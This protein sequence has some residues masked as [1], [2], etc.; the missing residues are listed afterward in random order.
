M[1]K[2]SGS[3]D[4]FEVYP[5]K[6]DSVTN[7]KTT[8]DNLRVAL[9]AADL[10]SHSREGE[11]VNDTLIRLALNSSANASVLFRK[12]DSAEETKINAW[13]SIVDERAKSYLMRGD[14]G[15]FSGLSEESLRGIAEISLQPERIATLPDILAKYHGVILVVEP[16]FKSM[17]MDGCVYNLPQG[18][19]VVGVS[20]RYN[21]YDNFWFTLMHE[22]AHI[23]LHYERL[24][25]PILDD[26]ELGSEADVEV[27][28]N[29]VAKDSLVSRQHWRLIWGV[30][31]KVDLMVDACRKA[32]VHPAIAAGMIRYQ[33]K[34]YALYPDLIKVMDVR[35]AFGF[36][37]D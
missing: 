21:R 11:A 12:N 10:K 19:P 5:P 7:F 16:G 4:D 32:D 14:V 24:N 23:S 13:L 3:E 29:I 36:S 35:R 25:N 27:E 30:R 18:T 31:D 20:V 34:N 17:K 37:D 26:L 2:F 22:L 28:A 1:D 9:S 6:R 15:R 33:S 8:L